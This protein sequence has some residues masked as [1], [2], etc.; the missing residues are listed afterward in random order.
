MA[1]STAQVRISREITWKEPVQY[2]GPDQDSTKQLYFIGAQYRM[3]LPA[4]P[5]FSERIEWKGSHPVLQARLEQPVFGVP[6]EDFSEIPGLEQ[7][8]DSIG[9]SV[10]ISYDRKTPFLIYSFIPLRKNPYNDRIEILQ[11]F[12]LVVESFEEV[13]RESATAGKFKTTSVLAE[14]PWVKFSTTQTGV[15]R[16][17]FSELQGMGIDAASIDPRGIRIFGNGGGM[18]PE[19]LAVHRYDDLEENAI[20]IEGEADGSFDPQDYILFYGQGPHAW[21]YNTAQQLFVHSYNIYAEETCYFLTYGGTQGKRIPDQE[22]ED[23]PPAHQVTSFTDYAFHETDEHNLINTGRTWYG[24][25]FD[26]KTSYD[27]SFSFPGLVTGSPATFRVNVAAKSS[28][29]STFSFFAN[30]SLIMSGTVNSLP[31]TTETYARTYSGTSTFN[32]L[33]SNLVIRIDYKKSAQNSIGWLNYFELNVIRDLIFSG[34]QLSFRDPSS[35]SPGSIAE[36]TLSNAGQDVRIWNVTDPLNVRKII[37]EQ[38]GSALRFNVAHDSISEFVAFDGSAFHSV[39]FK[40]SVANQDLHGA[41]PHDMILVTHPLFSAEAERLAQFH[42][43]HDGLSVLVTDIFK[44]YNE[45]SSGVQDLSAIRDFVRQMY[46]TAPEGQETRYLLLFGDASFD[47]KDRIDNNSNFIPTWEDDE[48]LTIVY[49]VAT[50]DFFG[51]LDGPGDDL[52]DIGIGRLPV[53]TEAEATSAVDKI[54]HYATNSASVMADWRNYITFVADDEDGNLHLNQAEEMA[55][56]LETNHQEYNIDKIYIDAFP[57]VA[58]PGGQRA[59]DVN[60][61][62]NDRIS[63]GTLVMNYTGHGGEVGWGHERFLEIVDINSWKNYDRM[64]I[65][66]TATCEFSRYDDPERLSAG[67]MVFRNPQGG[68]VA[69]FTT[70]RATFGGSNFNLNTALFEVMF[71]KVEGEYYCFGDLIRLAKNKNGV[72]ENDLKFILLGD[73][74]LTL[75]IP[76]YS[77]QVTSINGNPAG[78]Q[79]DTLLAL[80]QVVVE[81]IITD[82]QGNRMNDFNGTVS[83]V[84]FDKPSQITT[85]ASDDSSNPKTFGLQYNILYKGK[86]QASGGEFEFSFI[87]PKDIAYSYGAGKISFYGRT[88]TTDAHGFYENIIIGGFNELAEPDEEGP[89]ANL[90]MNDD[91]FTFGGITDENPVMLAYISDFSGIN[92]AG[93]G[94]GHDIIAILDGDTERPIVLNDY[95]EADLNSFTNGTVRYPFAGLSEGLHTLSLKVWDVFNNSGEAYTEFVVVGSGSVV[96]EDVRNY[97]NPFFDGTYITFTHNQAEAE[98]DVVVHIIDLSGRLVKSME[99]EMV[100]AGYHAEPIWWDGR[101]DGGRNVAKGMYICHVIARN[102]EG[103]TSEGFTKLILM[104]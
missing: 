33:S 85:L 84:V 67:E 104:H 21:S 75:A 11:S 89:V 83:P 102:E 31:P 79:P 35:A 93:S 95:Y 101:D 76:E 52:L 51:F 62:I 74:A 23:A 5:V 10:S 50:D 14:G 61:S 65:V 15:H 2:I 49:S 97:P 81:G 92:T 58:T 28:L 88:E 39:T 20:Y 41:G 27:F 48:S 98:L 38:A 24:E 69:M 46:E 17:S 82:D 13:A 66:I 100:T 29:P 103:A 68:A 96:I 12:D 94:I 4:V 64:P 90:F 8:P 6:E 30:N 77:V 42:R 73:P 59:P 87:V 7:L 1:E 37:A 43:S 63:K 99:K 22:S 56:F 80:S 32:P 34:G 3:D 86:T 54:I 26:V 70:A 44:V 19:S 16:I 9:V 91:A 25:V 57:Q 71:E 60:E 55:A 78:N 72:V 36:F 18:L 47:F 45:F 53:E 40:E